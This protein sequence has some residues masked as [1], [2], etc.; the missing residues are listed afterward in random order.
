VTA[1]KTAEFPLSV[2]LLSPPPKAIAPS[3]VPAVSVTASS[4]LPSK[5]FPFIDGS[6]G[7]KLSVGSL[8]STRFCVSVTPDVLLDKSSA[9]RVKDV[10]SS[11]LGSELIPKAL[12]VPVLRIVESVPERSRIATTSPLR[13]VITAPIAPLLVR[14]ATFAPSSIAMAVVEISLAG[15]MLSRSK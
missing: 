8:S 4:P 14:E 15:V 9:T 12:I 10:T 1:P 7:V 5:I 6:G 3:A 11:P 2:R 13:P